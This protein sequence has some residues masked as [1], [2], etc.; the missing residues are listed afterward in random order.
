MKKMINII[1]I[2]RKQKIKKIK[3]I[4][5]AKTKKNNNNFIC[6]IVTGI[7]TGCLNT[8]DKIKP[9][10]CIFFIKKGI[11]IITVKNNST[12]LQIILQTIFYQFLT[13]YQQCKKNINLKEIEEK[14]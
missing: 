3:V 5:H 12:D 7:I 8:I 14:C 10:S 9:Y 4:G 2:K 6:A 11:I 13:I 1:I